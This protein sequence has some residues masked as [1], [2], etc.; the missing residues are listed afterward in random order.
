MRRQPDQSLSQVG[1][2]FLLGTAVSS[3]DG[4]DVKAVTR[5]IEVLLYIYAGVAVL[6]SL[7]IYAY[8]PR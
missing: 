7:L 6:L 8:F 4:G 3:V 1:V 5:D 2:S